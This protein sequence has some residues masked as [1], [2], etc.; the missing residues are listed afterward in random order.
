MDMTFLQD[1]VCPCCG[2]KF[3]LDIRENADLGIFGLMVCHCDQYPIVADIPIIIKGKIEP[4]ATPVELIRR[5]IKDNE[6]VEALLHVLLPS[7]GRSVVLPRWRRMIKLKPVQSLIDRIFYRRFAELWRR[8]S[9]SRLRSMFRAGSVHDL[10]TWHFG[11]D[12]TNNKNHQDYFYYRFSQPRHLQALALATLFGRDGGQILDVGCGAGH[13][14]FNLRCWNP[15]ARIIGIDNNYFL[16]YLARH[17]IAP[18]ASYVCADLENRMPFP[19]QAFSGVLA[20]NCFHF[21]M[22]KLTCASEMQRVLGTQGVIVLAALRHSLYPALTHNRA[23]RPEHYVELFSGMP[24]RLL[25]DRVVLQRYIRKLAPDIAVTHGAMDF[26]QEPFVSL[27]VCRDE[28]VFREHAPFTQW[29]HGVRHQSI[30]P[31]FVPDNGAGEDCLRLRR[32][33]PSEFYVEENR[34]ILQYLPDKVDVPRSVLADNAAGKDGAGLEKLV[35]DC[36]LLDMPSAYGGQ[37]M[38]S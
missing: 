33:F 30:N 18:D 25:A 20:V 31:L 13:L 7:P 3:I 11:E 6:F 32:K 8:K 28:K 23:M 10:L 4:S 5:L 14:L 17:R 34:E 15:T 35:A 2:A 16:L 1:L 19:N 36:V 24:Y 27:V 21:L 29:P 37:S 12:G 9:R 22:N 26:T 38:T